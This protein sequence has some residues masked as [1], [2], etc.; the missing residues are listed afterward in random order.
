MR[1]KIVMYFRKRPL[2][3]D[4]FETFGAK[5]STYYQLFK[6]GVDFDFDMFVASGEEN[7]EYPLRFKN[8]FI[9]ESDHFEPHPEKIDADAIFDRSGGTFFPPEKI[10]SKVLN[11]I[12]F[13]RLCNDK[14]AMKKFLGDYMPKSNCIHTQE[15]LL[16][17]LDSYKEASRVALKPARGMQ[18][19]DIAIDSP[20]NIARIKLRVE[21]EYTLQEFIDTSSGIPGITS[22][23]HDLRI[24]IANGEIA[25]SHVRTPRRGSLLA[26]VAQGGSIREV[27]TKD[28]PDFIQ[29][30]TRKIQSLIDE[31]YD[32]PLYSID[33]GV[34]NKTIPFVFELNDQIGFPSE[35]MIGS[36]F[37]IYQILKSLK[38]RADR[39]AYSES[40]FTLIP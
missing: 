1:K 13:K 12:E 5:R 14:N 20:K 2:S 15:E 22:T 6:Q 9:Y 28:I 31:K 33:F 24:V 40:S 39:K 37:F 18:G 27:L 19:K 11:R 21:T 7:Y 17:H 36:N 16:F 29:D 23:Y 25:L 38:K 32:F 30:A 4:P 34:Q 8:T 35:A 3:R 10:G 26:N